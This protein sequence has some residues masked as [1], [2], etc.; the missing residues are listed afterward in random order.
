MTGR[1]VFGLPDVSEQHGLEAGT[2]GRLG[3]EALTLLVG[4][5]HQWQI[6]ALPGASHVIE[7]LHIKGGIFGTILTVIEQTGIPDDFGYIRVDGEEMRA[8][9]R[10]ARVQLLP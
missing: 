4:F 10:G 2:K 3:P 9:C 8:H 5:E 1:D 6:G 7:R